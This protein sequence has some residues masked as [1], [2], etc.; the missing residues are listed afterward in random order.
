MFHDFVVKG[1]ACYKK[2]F[3]AH[4]IRECAYNETLYDEAVVRR[5]GEGERERERERER[6]VPAGKHVEVCHDSLVNSARAVSYTHL[7]AHET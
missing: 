1:I 2:C 4:S 5:V 6:E 7:R 3:K